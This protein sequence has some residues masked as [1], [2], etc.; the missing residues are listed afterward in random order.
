MYVLN[1]PDFKSGLDYNTYYIEK[2]QIHI[3]HTNLVSNADIE[4]KV[5]YAHFN[6]Y[7]FHF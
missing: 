7:V 3:T 1:L 6:M 2:H 5:G 4:L